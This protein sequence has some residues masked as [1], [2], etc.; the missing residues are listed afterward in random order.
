MKIE[1]IEKN[2][3]N[4]KDIDGKVSANEFVERLNSISF[5]ELLSETSKI[6]IP[7]PTCASNNNATGM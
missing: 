4:M 6:Q 1:R 5:W 3:N 7:I 2:A